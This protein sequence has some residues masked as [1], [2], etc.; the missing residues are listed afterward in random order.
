MDFQPTCSI[1]LR[2]HLGTLYT[3]GKENNESPSQRTDSRRQKPRHPHVWSGVNCER[4][5]DHQCICRS[6]RQWSTADNKS[7]V[8]AASCFDTSTWQIPE[9]RFVLQATELIKLTRS[10]TLVKTCPLFSMRMSKI[11]HQHAIFDAIWQ[12]SPALL[13]F[14]RHW[15]VT[16]ADVL[17]TFCTYKVLY[18]KKAGGKNCW[19]NLLGGVLMATMRCARRHARGHQHQRCRH[20]VGLLVDYLFCVQA[21]MASSPEY[22]SNVFWCRWLKEYLPSLQEREKCNRPKRNFQIG[23]IVLLLQD[24][25]PRSS[26]PWPELLKSTAT[27][28]MAMWE[29]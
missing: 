23:D 19:G 29:V 15:P 9:R 27:A 12:V 13:T 24:N 7:P 17:L 11:R 16:K 20:G 25:T 2:W 21:E 5:T 26:W 6:K 10:P 8:V 22:L 4:K 18:A 14:R 28:V 1:P 3:N